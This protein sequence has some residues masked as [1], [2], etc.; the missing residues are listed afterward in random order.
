MPSPAF[1]ALPPSMAVAR[2]FAAPA[3]S[4]ALERFVFDVRFA[5]SLVRDVPSNGYVL[6]QNPGMFQV[7]G[8][9]AGQTSLVATRPSRLQ[10]LARQYP[11]GVY[12]HW[13]FWCNVQDPVQRG[14]CTQILAM[15]PGRVVRE[16]HV[17]DQRFALYS[18]SPSPSRR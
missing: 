15:S 14:Y 16:Q 18:L 11:G 8:V 3:R 9:N 5:E 10:D 17:R 12:F 4:L 2:A 1:A 13:N 7:W 6:T